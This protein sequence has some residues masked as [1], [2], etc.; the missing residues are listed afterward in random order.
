[1]RHS[2]LSVS[3][4]SLIQFRGDC[5]ANKHG[6]GKLIITEGKRWGKNAF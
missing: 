4:E 6:L 5:R 2:N 1:M 3:G